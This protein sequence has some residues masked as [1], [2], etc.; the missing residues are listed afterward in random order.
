MLPDILAYV[1][2]FQIRPTA[3]NTALRILVIVAG[4]SNRNFMR[5][6]YMAQESTAVEQMLLPSLAEHRSSAVSTS[7]P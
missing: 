4:V 7:P 6:S 1:V 5:N 2:W 3:A